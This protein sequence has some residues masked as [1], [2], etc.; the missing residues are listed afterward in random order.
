[1]MTEP[2]HVMIARGNSQV[3]RKRRIDGLRRAYRSIFQSLG[4][5]VFALVALGLIWLIVTVLALAVAS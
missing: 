5:V 3:R 1:M 4:D 2:L